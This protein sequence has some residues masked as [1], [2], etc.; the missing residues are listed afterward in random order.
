LIVLDPGHG[1]IDGGTVSEDETII[2][3][4]IVLNMCA[5]IQG[6]LIEMG[7]DVIN[8][9]EEDI[10]LGLMERTDIANLAK[11]DAIVSVHV[12]SYSAEYVNG[13]TTLYKTSGELAEAVQT[14]LIN[15]TGA[16]NMGMVKMI[17]LSILNRAEMDAI[18]VETGFITNIDESKLLES[19]EYQEKVADG[20]ANGI[21]NYFEGK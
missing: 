19:K 21:K 11:A 18:I 15:I 9:R 17:D 5:L 2:E 13:A 6:K 4:N 10:F 3:K 14:S 12:N 7:Y 1:G 20:I 16:N 8:L